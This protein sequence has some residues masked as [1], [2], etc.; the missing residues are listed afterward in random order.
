M[1]QIERVNDNQ[2]A[3]RVALHGGSTGLWTALPGIVQ[4][5]DAVKCTVSI[6][7]TI[8]SQITS[9]TGEVSFDPFA[10]LV[11]IPVIYMGGGGMVTTFPIQ[12]GDEALVIFADRCIDSWWQ[13]GGV[14]IPAEPR[15]H[16]LSDGFALIGPRSLANSIPNVS[17]TTAQF[18][19][20]D[21]STY[22][23]IGESSVA[24]IVAPGGINITGPV[25]ITGDVSVAGTVTATDE[26]TFNNIPVSV[27]KHTGVMTGGGTSG[28]P[29]A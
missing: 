19:S 7:P 3:L 27:H 15:M 25:T 4:S 5:Y 6:Q 17:T 14:Q 26:G 20:L 13:S 2:E 11:D 12:A 18:R 29:I 23:E 10:I 22:F 28:E 8:Q 24:N 9:P 16:T 21:G 1:L